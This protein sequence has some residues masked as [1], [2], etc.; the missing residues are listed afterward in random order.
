MRTLMMR[1]LV[2]FNHAG[3]VGKSSSVR[4]IG[5]VLAQL[6]YKVLLVDTD[7]QANLT[8][9]LG[10]HEIPELE[11]TIYP[12]I[13]TSGRD[14]RTLEL[15]E[16]IQ[17]H[18]LHLIPS[19]VDLAKLDTS[20]ISEVS[21]L[22][23]LRNALQK[24]D[25]YDFV[26]IDPPP[27]LGQISALSVIAADHVIVPLPTNSKGLHGIKTVV[28]MVNRYSEVNPKLNVGMFLLTQF[29]SRTNHDQEALKQIQE[30][31]PG[32]ATISSPLRHRPAVYKDAQLA[33]QPIPLFKPNDAA[34]TEIHTVTHELLLALGEKLPNE[35]MVVAHV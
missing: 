12:A 8:E 3:G 34:T 2:F 6:G 24:L 17:V 1:I 27:S 20:M 7:P 25:K 28:E 31:L 14:Y 13:I 15:P 22:P 23:R 9:W 4:D 35:T 33:G 19:Q 18:N 16:P 26:L 5:Y 29:D 21:P 30:Q 10:V 11:K 32:F